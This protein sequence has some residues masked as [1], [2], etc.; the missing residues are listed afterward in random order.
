MDALFTE[1]L[2]SITEIGINKHTDQLL[3]NAEFFNNLSSV[4]K[5]IKSL[6]G[7]F[8]K[9]DCIIVSAGPSLLRE[10]TLNQ[11]K[12]LI[13]TE[14]KI[15]CVDAALIRLLNIGIIPDFCVVLD[16]HPTRMLRWFGDPNLSEHSI[17][18]D[19]FQRQDLDISFRNCSDEINQ[20]NIMLINKFGPNINLIAATTLASTLY[21]RIFEIDF[22]NIY[23]FTPLVDNPV[24]KNSL[25]KNLFE[26]TNISCMNTGGNVGS[27]AWV[28]T[29][30]LAESRRTGAIGYD[31]SYYIDLPF[32]ETQSY[33]ELSLIAKNGDL[34]PYFVRG[35]A[36]DGRE[37]Y[38]DPTF[39]WYCDGLLEL[40]AQSK[41]P[42]YNLTEAGLLYG[43]NIISSNLSNFING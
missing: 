10:K 37:F 41:N 1:I 29:S 11:L 15:V 8:S 21:E 2:G 36:P 35:L 25:T 20:E 12:D 13:R 32:E 19:Y 4:K 6:K 39:Y 27:A 7:I 5:D 43:E 40:I 42:L 3:Q 16:P 24:I 31:Y 23:Y 34:T 28:F 33:S 9:N 18:D 17:D 22:K 38:Q 30:F 14:I 26:I